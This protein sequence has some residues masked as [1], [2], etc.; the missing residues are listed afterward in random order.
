[1]LTQCRITSSIHARYFRK[2]L[3]GNKWMHQLR[4]KAGLPQRSPDPLVI[5]ASHLE[6]NDETPNILVIG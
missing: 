5:R 2:T 4:P 1:R 3:A 6:T